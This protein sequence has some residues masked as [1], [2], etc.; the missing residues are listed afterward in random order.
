MRTPP[1][2]EIADNKCPGV[3]W[4]RPAATVITWVSGRVRRHAKAPFKRFP[5][6]VKHR[7][8]VIFEEADR[9]LGIH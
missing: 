5:P 6:A 8:I 7:I 4:P 1:G 3:V 9:R 2:C